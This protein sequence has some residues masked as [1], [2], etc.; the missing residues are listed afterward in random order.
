MTQ[1]YLIRRDTSAWNLQVWLSFSIAALACAIGVWSMPSEELDRAFLAIGLFFCLFSAFTLAKMIRDNRDERVDT[2]P[3]IMTVWIGFL[4]AVV[5]TAWGLFRMKIGT[6][7]KSYMVVSWLFLV[8]AAFTLAKLV[9]D[10]QEADILESS[11]TE[12]ALLLADDQAPAVD[13]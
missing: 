7:E 1:H 6:W 11:S 8:S 12:K 5:L 9:R 3:W 2:T 4:V 10:K 13:R